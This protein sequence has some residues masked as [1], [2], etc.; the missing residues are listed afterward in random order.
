MSVA[1]NL[2][3]N[4]NAILT[5]P[6]NLLQL[7]TELLEAL[8]PI[9]AGSAEASSILPGF[10]S[11]VFTPPQTMEENN[12]GSIIINVLD[13]LDWISRYYRA[14]SEYE[15]DSLR[16]SK[17]SCLCI[18]ENANFATDPNHA[19]ITLWKKSEGYSGNIIMLP[20]FPGHFD[21]YTEGAF[22]ERHEGK[23]WP[24]LRQSGQVPAHKAWFLDVHQRY[25][26]FSLNAILYYQY[27]YKR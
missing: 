1:V 5:K 26:N 12:R 18:N 21:F 24:R 3:A 22:R 16:E 15:D 19:V 4:I 17:G 2:P 14:L 13:Q 9:P 7:R 25:D 11:I 23:F 27:N 20:S 6:L 8:K 10:A